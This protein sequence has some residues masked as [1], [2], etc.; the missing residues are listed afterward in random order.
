MEEKILVQSKQYNIKKTVTKI[1]CAII[2][3]SIIVSI[4]TYISYYSEIVNEA[5]SDYEEYHLP[6]YE[7][8]VKEY[9]D[10]LEEYE[11][12][13]EI[14]IYCDHTQYITK[15]YYKNGYYRT[16]EETV[17]MSK[18]QFLENHPTAA[19]YIECNYEGTV[20]ENFNEYKASVVKE[21]LGSYEKETSLLPLLANLL[22]PIIFLVYLWL[23]SYSLTIT[24]KRVYGK[25]AFGKRVDLPLDSVS[26]VGTSA[27]K[28]VAVGTSSGKINFK[29]IKNQSEIH[30]V[31]SKL[32]AERQKV[33]KTATETTVNQTIV[34]TSSA[35]EIKKYKDLLDSGIITQEEFDEKKKQ[36]LNL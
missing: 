20:Y 23:R 26:S 29:L 16:Y 34:E 27:L 11:T 35:D 21:E 9:N 14:T 36:L 22:I 1:S 15:K 6:Y 33:E 17:P 19:S 25:T 18:S 12:K 13:E 2:V 3:L 8:L 31:I 28:G 4:F 24:D 10:I 5:K 32:L 30:D 7:K